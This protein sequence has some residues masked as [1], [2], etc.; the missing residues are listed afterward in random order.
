M[1]GSPPPEGGR[2]THANWRT[3]P[4][5]RWSYLHTREL[6]PTANISRGGGPV[7]ALRRQRLDLGQVTYRTPEQEHRTVA[8]FL[9]RSWT[10]ALVVLNRGAIQ[11]EEY[12]NEMQPDTRHIS[13][14]V[15]KSLTS[16]VIGI[17][18][19]R[20]LIDV[21]GLITDYIPELMNTACTGATVQHALDMQVANGWYAESSSGW[22]GDAA[23][24]A[25]DS[26]LLEVACGW[27]PPQ[28][29]AA[30]TLFDFMLRSRSDGRHGRR[31]QYSCLNTDALALIAERVTGQ[32][33][34]DLVANL[35]WMPA[36]ME[37]DGDLT[38]DLGGTA[39]ADGGYCITARDFARIGQLVLNRGEVDGRRVVP[40]A[41]ISE[42]GK[43]NPRPFHPGSYGSDWPGAAYHN[44]WW[45]MDDRL[46]AVGVHGQMI[47]VDYETKTVVVFLSSAPESN[48]LSQALAQRRIVSAISSAFR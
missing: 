1:V 32:R 33:F 39:V 12:R 15:G 38:V 19:D 10:D 11:V 28:A 30:T 6:I 36:G 9:D 4:W 5:S 37:F 34:A 27:L 41:W 14:S 35:L 20:G 29:G 26:S 8:E 18:V 16:L 2:V 23:A 44:H 46:M 17:L 43:P 47:A 3:A 40:E 21:A 31:V 13:M 24:G 42:Y 48:D 7:W 25:A 45:Q 22:Y